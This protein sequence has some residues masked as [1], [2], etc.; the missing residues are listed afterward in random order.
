MS[1]V[2]VLRSSSLFISPRPLTESDVCFTDQ[3]EKTQ[4]QSLYASTC[5]K[6][7]YSVRQSHPL[8][9]ELHVKL[10]KSLFRTLCYT[11]PLGTLFMVCLTVELQ[12]PS[13]DEGLKEEE[14]SITTEER[15]EEEDKEKTEEVFYLLCFKVCSTLCYLNV[16]MMSSVISVLL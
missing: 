9:T 4:T 13:D 2:A 8:L 12:A 10:E 11:S 7:M 3:C 6:G 5:C 14:I 1:P 16:E 15:K